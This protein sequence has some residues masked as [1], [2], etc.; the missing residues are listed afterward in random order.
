MTKAKRYSPYTMLFHL[1]NLVRNAFFFVIYLYVVMAG[2][3]SAFIKYGRMA[4][5]IIV[6][7]TLFS[8]IYKWV[9]HKYKLDD[10]SFH[11][12]KGLFSKTEQTIPFSK[13]EN[14]NRHTSFLHRVFKRTSIHFEIAMTGENANIKFEVLSKAEAEQ[15]EAHVKRATHEELED[16]NQQ[17]H[18]PN[19]EEEHPGDL[20]QERTIHFQPTK[21]DILKASVTSL[22]F[23]VL[24]P[25]IGSF[26]F[27]INDL[28]HVEDTAEGLI[29]KLANSWWI[30]AVIVIVLIVASTIFGLIRTY[31]K[32]GKYEI[33]SDANHIYI[34]R[35]VIDETAFS[36]SKDKVQAIEM[37]QSMIKRLLGLAEVKLTS[38]GG[39][40]S[41]EDALE[42]NTLYPFLPVNKAYEMISDMLPSYTITTEMTRLPTKSL[43]VRILRPSWFWFLATGA[44]FYFKPAIFNIEPSWIIVSAT[45]LVYLLIA[46]LFDFF[47]TR[48]AIN[49]QF[50]QLKKGAFTTSLFVSKRE[51]V[52]KAKI[53]RNIIQK[54]LGLASIEITNR[55]N[56]VRHSG[57][58]DV[59]IELAHSFLQWY[60]GREDDINV[61][62][63]P[64]SGETCS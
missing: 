30:V 50:I 24:I 5:L 33:A 7:L 54:R 9:T 55:G 13:I 17:S 18:D 40:R 37:E 52:I 32:Y 34:K 51:K 38:A 20:D 15:M 25:I 10:H 22:S 46:R 21:R 39:L 53:T 61:E 2:S 59:P 45:L 27:K 8:I 4:F 11:L 43:W 1:I 60:R 42:K 23:L 44:L 6:G 48:Y 63:Q 14:I 41:G 36:I 35:G 12:Y 58:D 16:W 62:K 28:F 49:D 3:E 29:N 26:Y 57:M 47:H 56:P 31:L 64:Y 19:D